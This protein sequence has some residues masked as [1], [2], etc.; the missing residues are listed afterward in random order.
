MEVAYLL[1]FGQLPTHSQ[2]S[3]WNNK[4][5]THTYLH[6]NM[7]QLMR[8]FRY[9]AHPMVSKGRSAA[10]EKEKGFDSPFLRV[11]LSVPC[12]PCPRSTLKQIPHCGCVFCNLNTLTVPVLMCFFRET[13]F[14]TTPA[15][16]TSSF[17]ALSE[18][19]R[20]LLPLRIAIALVGRIISR[21]RISAILRTSS[22][23][24][25]LFLSFDR[26]LHFRIRHA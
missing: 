14:T 15:C 2:L 10:E 12:Q 6:E 3:Q 25:L 8:N 9:D 1:I 4:V 5:M 26:C 19:F 22:V 23:R 18:S 20:R 11:C 24:T 21:D 16:G 7:V 17:T 13:L